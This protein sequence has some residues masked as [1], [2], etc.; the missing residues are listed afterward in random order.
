MTPT[1]VV[2]VRDNVGMA[3]RHPG[4]F[5]LNRYFADADDETREAARLRF[6]SFVAALLVVA[7]RLAEEE[8]ALG[9]SPKV[10]GRRTIPSV[11]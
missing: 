7:N 3:D 11:P 1:A 6:R 10:D 9:D 8:R 5:L 2:Q 4:D